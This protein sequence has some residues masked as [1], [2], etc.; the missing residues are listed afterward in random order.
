MNEKPYDEW[1]RVHLG[2]G[3]S[4]ETKKD[5]TNCK[6]YEDIPK[7]KQNI[8]NQHYIM[9]CT[10][11]NRPFKHTE[12][13]A[14]IHFREKDMEENYKQNRPWQY[15]KPEEKEK[16]VGHC[17]DC[18]HFKAAN[19]DSWHAT[20]NMG[21]CTSF[22]VTVDQK[23]NACTQYTTQTIKLTSSDGYRPK[24]KETKENTMQCKC[25][26]KVPENAIYCGECGQKLSEDIKTC[27]TCKNWD[28]SNSS[29]Y[30]K[31]AV[32]TKT[33]ELI[34]TQYTHKIFDPCENQRKQRKTATLWQRL[35]GTFKENTEYCGTEGKYWEK[36]S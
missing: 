5:C 16:T 1:C 32:V 11:H 33:S 24:P 8:Y 26:S 12:I 34:G 7:R 14:C 3:K 25:G 17:K 28:G 2:Q 23:Y 29:P 10:H 15:P 6:Q 36:K 19:Q 20:H 13:R 31:R 9:N 21:I 22:N 4:S 27:V 18:A 30:C 35:W